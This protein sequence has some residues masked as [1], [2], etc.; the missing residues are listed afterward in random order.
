MTMSYSLNKVCPNFI[1][2]QRVLLLQKSKLEFEALLYI[3]NEITPLV[4]VQNIQNP[5]LFFNQILKLAV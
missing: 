1:S 5:E 2:N 4:K 3:N